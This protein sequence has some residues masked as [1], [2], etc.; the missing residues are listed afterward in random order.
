MY[1]ICCL[2]KFLCHLLYIFWHW[3]EEYHFYWLFVIFFTLLCIICPLSNLL[4]PFLIMSCSLMID[5]V[6]AF[7]TSTLLNLFYILSPLFPQF[8]IVWHCWS[9][10]LL[11]VS[12]PFVLLL[13]KLGS[14]W[15]S[16]SLLKNGAFI[17]T[18]V[19]PVGVSEDWLKVRS[20]G[21]LRVW[22]HHQ[23]PRPPSSLYL[24]LGG[25]RCQTFRAT[26]SSCKSSL[27]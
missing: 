25:F 2:P 6:C 26:N 4:G 1:Q 27:L 17:C 23:Q 15:F 21:K 11:T 24:D 9:C 13:L 3:K 8:A 20:V 16:C 7:I 10:L 18:G 5:Q 22:F 12:Q 19:F 14:H